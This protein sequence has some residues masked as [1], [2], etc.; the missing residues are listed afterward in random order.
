MPSGSGYIFLKTLSSKLNFSLHFTFAQEQDEVYVKRLENNTLNMMSTMSLV[1]KYL[2]QKEIV[3]GHFFVVSKFVFIAPIVIDYKMKF[4]VDVFFYITCFPLIV[5]IFAI[6][7]HVLKFQSQ[8]LDNINI[9]QVFVGVTTLQPRNLHKRVIVLTIAVS[10]M[11]YS[12][13]LFSKLNDIKLSKHEQQFANYEDFINSELVIYS[14]L[15]A[16]K[17]D[18]D[19]IKK[20]LSISKNISN[21]YDCINMLIERNEVICV[22]AYF[23]GSYLAMSELDGHG[24]PIMKLS[25][26]SFRYDFGA[27]A[28]EKASPFAEK[29]NRIGQ[30]I[31]ESGL[32]N[33]WTLD[34][35]PK[36]KNQLKEESDAVNEAPLFKQFLLTITFIG[37]LLAT[38]AFSCELVVHRCYNLKS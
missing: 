33:K 1:N 18:S 26:L 29:F 7:N 38:L 27:Y 19:E 2:Y 30:L 9:F 37:Y 24:N 5:L 17:Y 15:K 13:D 21:A 14:T 34:D 32:F 31:I 8:E 36:T 25:D 28:Y 23:A 6:I 3:I 20:L 4:S 22:A 35:I 11:I 10:S 16:N 12:S